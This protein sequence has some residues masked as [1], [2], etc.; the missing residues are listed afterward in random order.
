MTP[1]IAARKGGAGGIRCQGVGF[2]TAK[3]GAV[4][5]KRMLVSLKR[6]DWA[7]VGIEF[8]LVVVG[9]LFA[10]QINEWAAEK[11][12]ADT[13]QQAGERLLEEV[14]RDVAYL[15]QA[16]DYEQE[17][18][19]ALR[20]G[21]SRARTG[22]GEPVKEASFTAR[23]VSARSMVALAPPSSVYD[24]IVSSGGLNRIGDEGVRAAIGRFRSTLS[25]EER[26]R[27]QLQTTLPSFERIEAFDYSIGGSGQLVASVNF[28]ALAGDR[29]ALQIIALTAE[30]HR[31]L[32]MLRTRALRDGMQVCLALAKSLG[33][34][35][36]LELQPPAFD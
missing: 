36:N 32:L 16:T 10:F 15:R 24:D 28:R 17:N 25:F 4:I 20:D 11:A 23:L 9:V 27:Q 30:N 35:C 1:I 31:I 7:M 5:V 21:L 3:G 14:E 33:R 6:Q 26:M 2:S 18:V 13:N 8:V 34:S 29:Q 19:D 22:R 12:S